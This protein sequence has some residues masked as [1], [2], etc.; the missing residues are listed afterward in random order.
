MPGDELHDEGAAA[1]ARSGR[2]AAPRKP[3]LTRLHVPAGKAIAIAAM[4]S[5]V[6]MGMGLTPQL[7]V[8]KPKPPESP[9]RGGPCVT[10]PDKVDEQDAKSKDKAKDK[11]DDAKDGKESAEPSAKPSASPSSGADEDKT[12]EPSA[13]PKTEEPSDSATPSPSASPEAEKKDGGLLGGVGDALGGLLGGGDKSGDESAS[14]SPSPSASEDTASKDSASGDSGSA[15]GKVTKP[16]EDTVDGVKD[17]VGKAGD[18][19]KGG[20][21]AVGDTVHGAVGMADNALPGGGLDGKDADGK[22][23]YPCVVENKQKGKDEQTP[24]TLPDRPWH[25]ESSALTLRGLD[26]EGVVNVTTQSGHTKQALKFTADSVDI[27]DLHQTVDD[28]ASGKKYHVQARKGSTSTI[29]G[30]KVTMYTEKLQGNLFG[31][32]PVTFDPEHPP[33]INTPFAVFTKVSIDQAGQFGGNLHV[34]GLQ[35]YMTG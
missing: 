1:G 4:P 13:T 7:A 24:V 6:L 20:S 23:G 30:G 31:L 26:Y 28:P 18:S 11:K 10:A 14:P 32:I 15:V 35:Q 2:H 5:A 29:R 9:F 17:G 25:L 19:L 3:L 12:S 34:P 16:V 21:K 33:P 27:G 8:A 22:K